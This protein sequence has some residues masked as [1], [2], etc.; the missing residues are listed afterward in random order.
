MPEAFLKCLLSPA[1]NFMCRLFG[2]LGA[3]ATAGQL[4]ASAVAGS[5]AA[6]ARHMPALATAL[7]ALLMLGE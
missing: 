1:A 5:A 7:P 2:F 3:G 6:A 4:A